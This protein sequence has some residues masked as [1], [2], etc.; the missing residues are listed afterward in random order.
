M[1]ETNLQTFIR[2]LYDAHAASVEVDY[3]DLRSEDDASVQRWNG[4]L[5]NQRAAFRALHEICVSAPIA[6]LMHEG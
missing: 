6:D 1:P 2:A 4:L 3:F 5:E